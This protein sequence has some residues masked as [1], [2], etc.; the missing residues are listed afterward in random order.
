MQNTVSETS[1]SDHK[2]TFTHH[3]MLT[4]DAQLKSIN[5]G[6]DTTKM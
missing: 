3:G 2:K 6:S 4:L 5:A 1:S